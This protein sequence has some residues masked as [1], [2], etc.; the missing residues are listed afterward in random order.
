RRRIERFHPETHRPQSSGMQPVE[1]LQVEPDEPRLR[2]E[3]QRETARRNLVAERQTP[4]ALLGE[5]RIAEDH[6]RAPILAAQLLELVGDVR[7][8]PRAIAG[9][10][11]VRAVGAELRTAAAR[12]EWIAA[13]QRP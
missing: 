8:R 5:E 12:Q 3:R 11:P 10:N 7:N 2:L 4:V 13:T 1:E 9:E 6:V